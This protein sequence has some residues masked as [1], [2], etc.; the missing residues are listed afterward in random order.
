MHADRAFAEGTNRARNILTEIVLYAACER[1]IGKALKKMSPKDGSE[2]MVAAVLNVKGDL[3]LDA[4]GA[5]RD[6][7]LCDAS[8][9]KARNLG[10]ELFEGIPPEE[11][12]L[13]QVAMVDLLK[14]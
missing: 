2:G 11:C 6:D 10:S 3:K 1:Q 14:P 9:E 7:S 5:V 8:E 12:V 13:E 4:L